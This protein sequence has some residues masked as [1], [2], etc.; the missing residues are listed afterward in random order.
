MD[1]YAIIRCIK[2]V[3]RSSIF[4]RKNPTGPDGVGSVVPVDVIPRDDVCTIYIPGNGIKTSPQAEKLGGI[5]SNEVFG[6]IS[7]VA[8]YV[9]VYNPLDLDDDTA[10]RAIQID[11]R[12]GNFVPRLSGITHI[13]L[14]E[15]NL[16]DVFRR[17]IAPVLSAGGIR[18]FGKMRFALDGDTEIIIDEFTKLLREHMEKIGLGENVGAMTR[19]AIA[20]MHPYNAYRPEYI[21]SL[22]N[23]IILPRISGDDGLR[24][25]A[26]MA[27][28]NI[29]KMNILTHCHGAYVAQMMA[30]LAESKMRELGYAPAEVNKILS[31]LLV[32]AFA[33]A[34]TLEKSKCR[35]VGFM[36]LSD[37][38]IDGAH[39]WVE[40]FAWKNMSD[41]RTRFNQWAP[42]WEWKLPPMVLEHN[43]VATFVVKRRFEYDN[44]V[45]GPN[46]T[47]IAEH[48][49]LHYYPRFATADGRFLATMARNVTLSGIRNSLAQRDAFTPLPDTESL[50][51]DG[52][53]DA[54]LHQMFQDMTANGRAFMVDVYKFAMAN[55]RKIH[56]RN[57]ENI[58]DIKF[59]IVSSRH[60]Q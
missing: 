14:T 42:D 46:N 56:P 4:L 2:M 17:K 52:Q 58:R 27:A 21:E 3:M 10:E 50:V 39:N 13:Y 35:F 37:S 15:K 44:E 51:L 53:H 8:N 20:N 19:H 59:D 6:N 33:P 30:E 31:Q 9:V 55:L 43:N 24:I 48:N 11:R 26:N 36:S 38:M 28:R 16:R 60:A 41:E 45:D 18:S 34:C 49:N 12:G 57:N 40:V 23:K 5:V 7:N 25:E 32:V 29:R 54:S 22:F 1:H 47:V